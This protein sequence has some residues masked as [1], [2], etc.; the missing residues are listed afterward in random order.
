MGS[1]YI[2]IIMLCRVVQHLYTKRSSDSVNNMSCFLKY[3]AFRQLLS[4][5]LG[6]VLI[7]I[8]Q[9]G[10][11][12]NLETVLI[13]VFAGLMIVLS[14]GFSMA[15]LKTGTVAL[16]A[17]FGTA[18]LLIPCVAG[19]FLFDE[20]MSIGQWCGVLMFFVAAYFLISSSSKIYSR[21]S[22][23]TFFL[24]LGIMFAE[25]FT[26]LAQQMFTF[27]VPDG[28][29]S[30]FSFLSFGLV[31]VFMLL[32]SFIYTKKNGTSEDFK[33]TPK[34]WYWGAVLAVAIFVINQL[35]TLATAIVPPVILFTFIN[36]GSTIIGAVVAAVFFREKL[37]VRSTVGIILGVLS[38][39]IIKAM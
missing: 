5:A 10:F 9:N 15:A 13:S 8:A 20:P 4:G 26:M 21:F 3:S 39:V 2:A 23:K 34:L 27:Y 22:L 14:T 11:K 30:V 29:V 18:G 17:L 25:G 12:C 6:L 28:D 32:A 19:I 16:A 35:A 33:L 24:L 1:I 38:M 31:G 7:L 36:G 37:T